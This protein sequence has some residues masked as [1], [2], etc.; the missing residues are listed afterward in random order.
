VTRDKEYGVGNVVNFAE[1]RAQ[2]DNEALAANDSADSPGSALTEEEQELRKSPEGVALLAALAKQGINI[3]NEE[4]LRDFNTVMK[5]VRGMKDRQTGNSSSDDC[6]MLECM[7]QAL[8]YTKD[9]PQDDSFDD[10]LS[11]LD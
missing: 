2:R 1:R 5:L 8:G 10:L 6:M 3:I 11:K 4:S 7:A 9:V